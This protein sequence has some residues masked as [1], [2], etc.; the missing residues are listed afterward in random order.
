LT[1]LASGFLNPAVN[2]DGAPFGLFVA[3]PS[4]GALIPLPTSTA[5][6][7]VIHNAADAAAAE[8]DVY[9]NGDLRLDNFAFR[10][11]TPFIDLPAGV[12][13]SVAI[14]PST[15]TSVADAIATFNY[16]L[17]SGETYVIVANGIVSATGYDPVQPFNLFVYATGREAATDTSNTDVLVF[18]GSTDAPTVDVVAVGAGTI[19]N[20]LSYSEFEPYL[21]LPTADYVLEVRDETGTVTVASFDAPLA[22]L[23]LDGAALTVLASGFLNPAVNSDGAPFGLFVALPSGGALIP[24]P[25][26]TARAQ[27]IHNA[28]DAAAAE[29]DVY[30][31]GDLRLDNFAFRTATPFID[32]PAGVTVSVAIAPSTSTSVADAIATFN[33]NLASGETYVIVANGI[34]S[35]T[36]YD[37]VQPFNLFVYATGREAATDTS[38]TDVLVFHGSTDAPTVD[39]VAVGAGTIVNDLSYSEFA[40]YLELPTADYV[41]E[42]RDETGTVTVASFD[43][44]LAG[45]DLDGAALTVLASGFLNPAV[46]SDGAP[47]GL[48]VALPSGGALIPLPTSTAR[49]QVIHNAA[50]AAAAEVDVYING[51]LRL[52]NFAFRTATPFID[53]PAGVTVSVAI[54]PS[55][56]T[57]VAD[58]IATFNYNLASGETYVIVANGIVS[59]T[60]YDPVQPFNLFVYATGRE[61]ATDTSNTDVL[62]FHGST[63]AP[64]VDV[65]AVGAGTIVNDLSYSEFAGYLELPTA[66]YVLEVKDETGATTVKAYNAP[67]AELELEGVALTVLAS[68]FL[69]PA[70]NSNGPAF[71]LWVALPTGGDLIP[72]PE[73]VDNSTRPQFNAADIT[74]FPNPVSAGIMNVQ[75]SNNDRIDMVVMY[76]MAGAVVYRQAVGT[77]NIGQVRLPAGISKGMYLVQLITESGE[78]F[79]KVV[80]Q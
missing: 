41:L 76:N 77:T 70:N 29:V 16:N 28:A 49:A 64:T 66:D 3:L 10:T 62:V 57:S 47:F 56:S 75:L 71:G 40:G 48:F 78:G 23:N 68:G 6:A 33:Y 34:V 27:V 12:T 5:R 39:V 74:I 35:A 1:V 61:A 42:V 7:Q 44:P 50:D 8:V 13:V 80:V 36:G 2:S 32:L 43:A 38:N 37:P 54:A 58:A 20:D 4:G 73:R 31:N 60:G 15:S 45:L 18:H 24:L 22:G 11:A 79:Q 52:D 26:S 46:N 9:I 19:V 25:T 51:D 53:L 55:T 59:A 65:V 69:N 63:D 21:E 30:I 14:A 67:L 72:L 17:A